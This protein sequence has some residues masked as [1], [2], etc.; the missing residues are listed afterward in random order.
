MGP[1]TKAA[2]ILSWFLALFITL[3]TV[4]TMSSRMPDVVSLGFNTATA[5]LIKDKGASTFRIYEDVCGSD[6]EVYLWFGGFIGKKKD[7]WDNFL[8]THGYENDGDSRG[9]K[10]KLRLATDK[11]ERTVSDTRSGPLCV[12]A[13]SFREYVDPALLVPDHPAVVV[14]CSSTPP[15]S[16]PIP[17]AAAESGVG[18]VDMT[19]DDDV[20]EIDGLEDSL[21]DVDIDGSFQLDKDRS[22]TSTTTTSFSSDTPEGPRTVEDFEPNLT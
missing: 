5:A 3:L 6:T 16:S 2:T 9:K 15:P 21:H 13:Y 12:T 11:K 7:R 19:N 18:D 14:S 22:T 4:L 17:A 1:W 8:K 20:S 10:R